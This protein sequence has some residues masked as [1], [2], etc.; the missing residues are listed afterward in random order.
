MFFLPFCA[1]PAFTD[2]GASLLIILLHFELNAFLL[3]K[4]AAELRE[5][6]ADAATNGRVPTDNADVEAGVQ[7]VAK[8]GWIVGVLVC[9]GYDFG[10]KYK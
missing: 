1:G 2:M 10:R 3:Q 6:A 8:F 5:A 7:E 4:E 9:S